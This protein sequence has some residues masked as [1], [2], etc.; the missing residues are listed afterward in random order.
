MIGFWGSAYAIGNVAVF[1]EG[2]YVRADRMR[3]G[4]QVAQNTKLGRVYVTRP[5]IRDPL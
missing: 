2:L 5:S 4:V 3:G 1:G